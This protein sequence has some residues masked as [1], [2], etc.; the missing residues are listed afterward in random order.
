MSKT[1]A[2]KILIPANGNEKRKISNCYLRNSTFFE[3]P[4]E[5]NKKGTSLHKNNRDLYQ[6][7]SSKFEVKWSSQFSDIG[8][9][10]KVYSIK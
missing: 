10:T 2:Q 5:S 6:I 7:T 9:K 3:P 8:D 1:F 4:Q